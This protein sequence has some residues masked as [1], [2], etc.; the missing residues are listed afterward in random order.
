MHIRQRQ[1]MTHLRSMLNDPTIAAEEL[2]DAAVTAWN[3]G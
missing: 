1:V 2:A 3:G